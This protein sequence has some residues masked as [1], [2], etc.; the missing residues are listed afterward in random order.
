MEI[1]ISKG[2]NESGPFDEDQVKSMYRSGMIDGEDLVWHHGLDEWIF[3]RKFLGLKPPLPG[4][5]QTTMSPPPPALVWADQAVEIPQLGGYGARIGAYLLDVLFGG[6]ICLPLFFLA[7]GL[8]AAVVDGDEDRVVIGAILGP[9]LSLFAL[10][11]GRWLYHSLQESSTR[12]ATLG[13]M[14]FGL[15]VTDLYGNRVTKKEA[16]RRVI[17]LFVTE[18]VLGG[19]L[20][21][22]CFFS[23]KRQCLHDQYAGTLVVKR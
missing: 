18:L 21:I 1:H 20:F 15:K 11:L 5:P 10:F 16:S 13:Q 14:V 9:F 4:L 22:A 6:I 7:I 12:Q 19:I 8:A 2:G 23:E 17:S 3:A